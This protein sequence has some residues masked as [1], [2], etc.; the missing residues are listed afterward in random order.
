MPTTVDTHLI[1]VILVVALIAWRVYSR[2]R[3]VIGRQRLSTLR[4]WITVI[5]FPLVLVLILATSLLH[6]LTAVAVI[7]GAAVGI[8]L[9]L[10]GTRLTKFEVTPAGLFYTPN[11]HLGIALSLLLVLR[12]GYRIVTLAM[13][14]QNLDPQSMQLGTSPLTMA[15]FGTL[16]GYYVTYAIGLLRWR[17][18]A[19]QQASLE[20]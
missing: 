8:A 20:H 6:P 3:R 11:A 7:T 4:P 2:I 17:A 5:V 12:I 9:G 13:V 10:L 14:G 1:T 16:A 18:Q 15:I 19:G